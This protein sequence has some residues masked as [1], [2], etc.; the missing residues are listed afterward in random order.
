MLNSFA[1]VILGFSTIFIAGITHGFTG[2][3]FALTSI[4]VLIIFISPKIIVP[5]IA[6]QNALINIIL[7]YDV[8]QW[9]QLKRILPL[10]ATSVVG[11]LLGAYLLMRLEV[12]VLKLYIGLVIVIFASALLLGFKK[13]IKHENIALAPVGFLSGVLGGS[14][15]MAG[16]PI[17]LFFS[18]QGLKMDVFRANL[19]AYFTVLDAITFFS[20]VM[21]D[22]VDSV[23]VNYIFM[24]L[25][26]L[27][28]GAIIGAKIKK[29]VK[30]DLFR[31]ITLAIVFIAGVISI[32]SSV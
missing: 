29:R 8:K 18:N 25:P 12:N 13:E 27:V 20:F 21:N 15:S 16:P 9:V 11:T 10:M 22:L 31:R 1:L 7:L 17:I 2:F 3:G 26:A 6:A 19:I 14:T 24:F 5:V 30:E 32:V 4:P 28:L 23:V